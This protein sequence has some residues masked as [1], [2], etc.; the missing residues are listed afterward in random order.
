M[1]EISNVWIRGTY[2][3]AVAVRVV[4]AQ[5]NTA[6]VA[7]HQLGLTILSATGHKNMV[8]RVTHVETDNRRGR[9]RTKVADVQLVSN[10][11]TKSAVNGMARD[12]VHL[13][14]TITEENLLCVVA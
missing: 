11:V 4:A 3:G 6:L 5:K 10:T 9:S 12:G 7:I 1:S 14:D 13:L 2:K 8:E